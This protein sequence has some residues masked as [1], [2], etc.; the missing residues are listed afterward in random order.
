MSAILRVSLTVTDLER[1][2]GFYGTL[3]FTPG[4]AAPLD[5]AG[6][7]GAGETLR[8][9]LGAQEI[10]LVALAAPG[11]PYPQGSTA[12]DLWFQHFAIVVSDM[13][14]AYAQ[15]GTEP[16]AP[17]T[18]GPPQRLPQSAG[19]VTAFKFR[20]L[21]GHPIELLYFPESGRPPAWQHA[22]GLFLGID[23]T[24]ISVAETGR[25]EAFY[26]G[27]GLHCTTHTVNSGPEQAHLDGLPSPVADVL[28]LAPAVPTP[29]LELL[30]YRTPPGRPLHDANPRDIAATRTVLKSD[31]SETLYDPDGHAL[32]LAPG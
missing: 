32:Q 20:D 21:D 5:P 1:A 19:A 9:T 17:I 26:A 28:G 29:H 12:A 24:A 16:Y 10:E 22:R 31:R 11:R 7:L 2:A 14:A 8:L 18:Q 4:A 23:H 27:L 30:G 6:P 3:G 15:L 13:A 25:S